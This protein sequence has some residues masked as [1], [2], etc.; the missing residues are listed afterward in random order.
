MIRIVVDTKKSAKS[1]IK[2]TIWI[3][4]TIV[5]NFQT[6][7]IK[8]TKM[9]IA[10]LVSKDII[11]KKRLISVKSYQ[12]T[13][14]WSINTI[15]VKNVTRDTILMRRKAVRNFHNIVKRL[16]LMDTVKSV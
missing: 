2:D 10:N 9:V 11:L 1:V 4:I 8:L 12:T 7:V 16:I 6:I 14:K 3:T 15:N 5:K 13:V